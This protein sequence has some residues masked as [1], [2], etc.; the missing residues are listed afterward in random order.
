MLLLAFDLQF[1]LGLIQDLT[2]EVLLL[3]DGLFAKLGSQ[4]DLLV[5]HVTHL[6]NSIVVIGFLL[7]LLFL[8]EFLAELLDLAPLVVADIGGHVLNLDRLDTTG[9]LAELLTG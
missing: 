5:E 4:F 2:V 9:K 8:V 6:P 1:F 7:P 3:L